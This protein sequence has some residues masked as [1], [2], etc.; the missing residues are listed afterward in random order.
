V[1]DSDDKLSQ[2]ALDLMAASRVLDLRDTAAETAALI[3]AIQ[4]PR[5]SLPLDAVAR[6]RVLAIALLVKDDAARRFLALIV[7]S[8]IRS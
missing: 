7:D 4:K 6:E 3:R 1:R 2:L 8:D 5:P